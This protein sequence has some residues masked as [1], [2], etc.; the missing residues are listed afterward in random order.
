MSVDATAPWTTDDL[1]RIADNDDLHVS[2]YRADGVTPGTPTWIWAVVVDGG[3]YVRAYN[4]QNSRWYRAAKEQG[5]GQVRVAGTTREVAFEPLPGPEDLQARI[6]EAYHVRYAD[7][8][9]LGHM[10]GPAARAATVRITPRE[11]Q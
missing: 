3:L 4:G 10:V 7:S 6:D 1:Q 8:S 5:A 11:P 2:P 9:Y